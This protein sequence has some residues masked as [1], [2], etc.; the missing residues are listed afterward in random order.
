MAAFCAMIDARDQAIDWLERAAR[1]GFIN[2]PMLAEY[3]PFLKRLRG[4][5]RFARLLDEVK[6]EWESLEF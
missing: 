6:R 3:D 4:E 1:R 5:P 2:Y